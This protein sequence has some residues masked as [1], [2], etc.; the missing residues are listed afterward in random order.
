LKILYTADWHVRQVFHKYHQHLFDVTSKQ[1]EIHSGVA[2]QEHRSYSYTRYYAEN[3][4][5][6][7][8]FLWK[9]TSINNF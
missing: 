9:S 8:S 2:Q 1:C 3:W 6:N 5:N 4:W 7:S